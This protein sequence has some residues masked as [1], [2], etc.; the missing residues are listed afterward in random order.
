MAKKK[1]NT[2]KWLAGAAA[3]VVAG[4]AYAYYNSTKGP[5]VSDE[6]LNFAFPTD[7][8]TLDSSKATDTYSFD[9]LGNSQEGLLRIGKGGKIEN[10]EAKSVESSKDGLTWTIKLRDGLKWSNGDDV[11]AKDYVYSWQRTND[12]KTGSEYAYIFSGIKNA[13]AIQ[14][15]KAKVDT[16]GIKATDDKTLVVT[17]EKPLPQFKQLLTFPVLF[18]Q[19][20]KTVEKYGKD[21]GTTSDKQVYNGAYTFKGWTGTNKKY[22]L[23]K[24]DKYWDASSVKSKEIDLQVIEKPETQVALYKQGKLDRASL[25]TPELLSANK[26]SKDYATSEES[27]AAYFQYNEHVKALGNLKIRQALNLATNRKDFVAQVMSGVSTPATGLTP[28]GTFT[29]KDGTDF[30]AYA[31]QG[32]TYDAAEAKKLWQEGLKEIGESKVTLT[33]TSD[34]DSPIAK[35]SLDYISQAWQTALPGLT[36]KEKFVPFQQRLTDTS[37]SNFQVVLNL[38]GADYAEPSTFVGLFASTSP[39]NNGFYKSAA[40]D[41]AYKKATTTDAL[42]PTKAAADYKDAEAALYKEAGINP[43][44]WRSSPRLVNPD[45]KGLIQNAAGAPTDDFKYAYKVK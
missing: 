4:G 45:V 44:Y 13:D 28:A 6:P 3:V 16:L 10:A 30:A 38:W 20:Q 1:S 14:A 7:I 35:S 42:D 19:N 37:S 15:G 43:L 23:V 25:G 18:P 39:N 33:I 11:T 21:Y 41:A 5:A 9:V 34:A 29:L 22:K 12:P 27:T 17:L 32:Y 24:N 36:V 8:T 2:P 40:Y 26:S 31:K